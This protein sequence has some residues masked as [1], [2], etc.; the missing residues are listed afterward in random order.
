MRKK[1]QKVTILRV[2]R[3]RGRNV[4]VPVMITVTLMISQRKEDVS[5]EEIQTVM[6]MTMKKQVQ[7][8]V[9]MILEKWWWWRLCGGGGGGASVVMEVV[10][11]LL[12]W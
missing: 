1:M 6:P 9:V 8:K 4:L 10:V 11:A 7:A 3:Q 5:K 2:K 12:W